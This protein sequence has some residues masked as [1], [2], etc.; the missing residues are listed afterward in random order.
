MEN[1][2]KL[3]YYSRVANFGD[4]LNVNVFKEL[5]QI[6]VV[7]SEAVD[8]EV[9]AIGSLLEGLFIPDAE[10]A[11]VSYENLPDIV[12]WGTGFIKPQQQ[13]QYLQ[14]S[15]DVRALR[16][17]LSQQRLQ[18]HTSQNLDDVVLGDPGLLSRRL[19][20]SS[21]I[22]K[23]YKL[24]IIP[25]YVEKDSPLLGKINVENAI[26]LDI[27]QPPVQFL[28]QLAQCE[29]VISSAMHGL[30]ASDSLGIPNVRMV[31]SDKIM[32]G[33]YKFNDYYSAF[34]LTSHNRINLSEQGFTDKDIGSL[35]ANYPIR[36]EQ[37]ERICNNLTRVFPYARSRSME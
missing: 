21:K 11:K 37:V 12:V 22:Q 7:K 10:K 24:G 27:Q 26:V 17:R 20:D 32:G 33:D 5:F 25:H 30:I 23:K 34:G 9:I 1:L 4:E 8:A 35:I 2:K 14:R 19:I 6:P 29:T 18:Q 13:A 15:L 28:R 31:L 36:S 3:Y 16:G